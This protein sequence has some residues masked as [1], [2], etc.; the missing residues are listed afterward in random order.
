MSRFVKSSGAVLVMLAMVLSTTA[1]PLLGGATRYDAGQAGTAPASSRADGDGGG[2]AIPPGE[3][4]A[5][6][7]ATGNLIYAILAP[8]AFKDALVP[9]K[10]WKTKKGMNAQIF[11]L[12]DMLAA[13]T[14]DT[15]VPDYA[16]VHQYLRKLYANNPDFEWVL[17]VGDGD[18]DAETFP[19]PYI[20][21]NGS[22]DPVMGDSTLL[23]LVASDVMYSGLEHDWYRSYTSERWWE[24]RNEDW[25]PEVYVGRWPSKTTAE[26]TL[27]VNRVLNYEKSPPGGNWL[28][29]ALFAG[30]LYDIPNNVDPDPENWTEYYYQWPHDNGRTPMI[31]CGAIFPAGMTKKYMFDYDQQ[32]GGSY[33]PANDGLSKALFVSEF[34][35]GYS[36]VSTA[37]HAWISGNGINNY[38][39]YGSEPPGT[40]ADQN[41]ESFF[42][43]TDAAAVTNGGRLP[44][45]YSSACD[46]A[47][48]TTFFYDLHDNHDRTLEQLLKNQN[49]GA[50]GFISATNGDFWHQ[51]EG[52]WW[53]E[54][55]FWQ[56][57]FDG[58][59]RPGEALYKSKVA[60]DKYLKGIGRN[61]DLPRIRQNKAIYCLLGD[62]E[63]P[64]W[65]GTPGTLTTD[66]MPQLYT[67][68]QAVTITVRDA[69]TSQPVQNAMVAI[70][71]PGT[72]GRGFTDASGA[73]TFT[74]DVADPGTVNVTVTAHN[75]LPYETAAGVLL[76]PAD[77]TLATGDITVDG[78]GAVLR[79][80]E[81]AEVAAIIHNVGRM[82]ASDVSVRFYLGDPDAGGVVIGTTVLPSVQARGNATAKITWTVRAG[83]SKLYVWADPDN[84]LAEH[85]EDNNIAF[86]TV[87]VS[88]YDL[89]VLPGGISFFPGLEIEGLAAAPAG[90]TLTIT[91]AVVNSGT[92][93]VN[94][95]Y[96]R[97]YDGDPAGTGLP[98]EG[99]KRLEDIQAGGT[100]NASVS[101][102]GTTPGV[103]E[104][105]VSADPLDLV[106]E[107]DE[108]N[109]R[110]SR[111]VRL[112]SPPY[113]T[114]PIEDQATDEDRSRN[115]Y[116]DLAIYVADPDND[117]GALSFRVISQTMPQANV[118]VTA[119]G[120]VSVRPEPDWNGI[121]VVMVGVSDGVSEVQ[122]SFNMTVRP[123][124][125]APSV[126]D[127]PP[128]DLSVGRTYIINVTARDIDD[129]EVLAF[130]ADTALFSINRSTGRITYTPSAPHIGKHSV[131]ITV[132]D[133]GG[134]AAT[135]AWRF[136]VSRAN[137]APVLLAPTGLVL[138]AREGRPVYFKFNATDAEGDA[139]TFSDD[140]PF[141]NINPSTGEINFTP[142]TQTAG[143][144]WFNITV[145][146]SGGLDETRQFLLNISK[147][148]V[149]RPGE[150]DN[151]WIL[152]LALIIML[153]AAAAGGGVLVMRLRSRRFS[154]EDEKARYEALYGAGTYERAKKGHS[155]SLGE[156][157]R[158]ER[159]A[160][161]APAEDFEPERKK[162]SAAGHNCPR[163]G[164][165][166]V[167]IFPDGG[168]I[169]NNCGKMFQV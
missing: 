40:P 160:A 26:V 137:T 130:S 95:T 79:D 46:A 22:N 94:V 35:A 117:V 51:T 76:I 41:F 104:I 86:T 55:S 155:A 42:Y 106:S 133:S 121:S 18:A 72:F 28:N 123:Q 93:A 8:A 67:V 127:M 83:G 77:L 124:N 144:Y 5:S 115:A 119:A 34:N 132:T 168:A 103:H 74:V 73:A 152:T 33:N 158:K 142:P 4:G 39:G 97:F 38:I 47:N 129:N 87:N 44:L 156:F 110:G 48:F 111:P 25:T 13:Y 101:W 108:T 148:A 169:C 50:I 36:L 141:F 109:N 116:M 53:L 166:K 31:D 14:G 1:T 52:N 62:P 98:I 70:T 159:A 65:T 149:V 82:S 10:D 21:T 16:K 66:A 150:P 27:N 134:L 71:A 136:N 63:V 138:T 84:A 56:Q 29:S 64:V 139:L 167:Q 9:L 30:A 49:G 146:D 107:F 105:F 157:R 69:F 81:Q 6:P 23:N 78:S 2:L 113:F 11:T 140:S 20:F 58:S 75:Y 96:V 61:T 128:M 162:H 90:S 85:R 43:Y 120:L 147:P 161:A 112:D 15:A 59:Y 153:I 37:S 89:S 114:M 68:P 126:E 7:A 91:A 45:M 164:S 17:V 145:S 54:K 99:D 125:D 100:A 80:G 154:E 60:Y 131:S 151:G 88:P 57:F 92:S 122:A 12:E 3:G 163:C 102:N 118:S 24:T 32:Y 143:A 165:V 19:V 135:T